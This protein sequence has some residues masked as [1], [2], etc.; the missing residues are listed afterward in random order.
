M[1]HTSLFSGQGNQFLNFGLRVHNASP[2][3]S[4]STYFIEVQSL[5]ITAKE[6]IYWAALFCACK[7]L[8]DI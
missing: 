2:I 3:N 1:V 5:H 4:M 8:L 7:V 6:V